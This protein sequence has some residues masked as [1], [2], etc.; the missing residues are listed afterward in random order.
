MYGLNAIRGHPI[1]ATLCVVVLIG[2]QTSGRRWVTHEIV[3][4]WNDKKG[5]VGV[6][7]HNLKNESQRQDAK[8]RNPFDYVT[9]GQQKKLS[10]VVKAYDPPYSDSA[11][12]YA[13]IAANL[14]GWVEE[15]IAI[16][17]RV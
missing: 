5:V 4:G 12:V 6:Y 7:I 11:Q 8:G 15:A 2:S 9:Y 1:G 14:S 3:K 13:H 10:A 17:N 16:R